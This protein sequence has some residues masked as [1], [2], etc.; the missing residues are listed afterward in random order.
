[1]IGLLGKTLS[2][3]LSKP[4]HEALGTENYHLFETDDLEQFIRRSAF[5]ALNVTI[6][7]KRD[8]VRFCSQRDA[9]VEATGVANTIIRADDGTLHAYNT[10]YDALRTLIDW[11]APKDRTRPAAIIG[12][13]ST[14]RTARYALEEAGFHDIK[15]YARHPNEGE[16]PLTQIHAIR[17]ASLLIQATPVGTH[18]NLEGGFALDLKGS[19]LKWV[20]D[21]VYNPPQ[22]KLVQQARDANI[23]AHSGLTM[24][25]L[26]ALYAR[27]HFTNHPVSL[28]RLPDLHAQLLKSLSNITLIGP[29]FSG[30][31]TIAPRLAERLGKHAVDTDARIESK[32]GMRIQDIFSRLGEATFRSMEKHQTLAVAAQGNQVIATGGG[33]VLQDTLMRALQRTGPVIHIDPNLELV[34]DIPLK[35]RPLINSWQDYEQLRKVRDPLYA[36]YADIRL[37]K[38]SLD[39]EALLHEIEVKLDAYFRHQ[40]TELESSRKT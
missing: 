14:A 38:T 40:W 2:H 36:Q 22:T 16:Y 7:Y 6:P 8:I 4:L 30:K 26:Q 17:Q 18:P 9:V 19:Q 33:A 35:N 29:P 12:N 13:G 11:H 39:L 5:R 21:V 27:A 34:R 20:L 3:S 24:L 15:T 32:S 37:H 25:I 23:I 28:E 1:M 31:S 10:D